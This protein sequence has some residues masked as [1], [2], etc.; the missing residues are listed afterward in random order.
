MIDR[1]TLLGSIASGVAGIAAPH[2]ARAQAA[3]HY[4]LA[5][6]QPRSSK[7]QSARVCKARL[8]RPPRRRAREAPAVHRGHMFGPLRARPRRP[9]GCRRGAKQRDE[10]APF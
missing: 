4:R 3:K 10:L 6:D 9:S 8:T 5:Y 7:N 2:V 1:R